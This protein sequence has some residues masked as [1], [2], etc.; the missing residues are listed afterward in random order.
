MQNLKPTPDLLDLSLREWGTAI[1]AFLDIPGDST[2]GY[3]LSTTLT[4]TDQA[5]SLR[6]PV[7]AHHDHLASTHVNPRTK[8]ESDLSSTCSSHKM[9]SFPT[10]FLRTSLGKAGSIGNR[11]PLSGLSAAGPTFSVRHCSGLQPDPL[12]THQTQSVG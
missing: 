1:W 9:Q 2:E 11:P 7:W 12:P 4:Y 10:K 8:E 5:S 6:V 3:S